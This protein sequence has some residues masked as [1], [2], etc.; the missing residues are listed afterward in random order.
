MTIGTGIAIAAVWCLPIACAFARRVS[1]IGFCF[2]II[3]VL[4]ATAML[5]AAR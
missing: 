3:A 4:F 2:S 1:G 5:A